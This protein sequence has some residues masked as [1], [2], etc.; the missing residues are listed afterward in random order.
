[1]EPKVT[2]S[3]AGGRTRVKSTRAGALSVMSVSSNAGGGR[4]AAAAAAAAEADAEAAGGGRSV[5]VAG[6]GDDAVVA[7]GLL[8][9]A[10]LRVAAVGG[11]AMA[12]TARC[13]TVHGSRAWCAAGEPRQPQT[14]SASEGE[15]QGGRREAWR[16]IE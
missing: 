15:R 8:R 7:A 10:G 11:V 2:S 5:V 1:M 6:G 4:R 9:V 14:L 13:T 3:G 16:V 12:C